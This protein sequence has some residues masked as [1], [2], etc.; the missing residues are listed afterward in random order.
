LGKLGIH[1][2]NKLM[3]ILS[4]GQKKRVA[5]AKVLIDNP[6]FLILDEPTSQQLSV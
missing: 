3:T 6:D 2:F 1:D 4:D 5:L